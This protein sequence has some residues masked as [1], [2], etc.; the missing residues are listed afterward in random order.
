MD[1]KRIPNEV[2][3]STLRILKQANPGDLY[4][5]AYLGH[6]AKR[7]ETFFDIYH[8]AWAWAI[9]YKPKRILEIGVRTGLSICQLLSAY[10]KYDGIEKI[11]LCDVFNDG[12][13]SPELVK[14]NLQTLAIPNEVISK[15]EFLVG[16]SKIHIPT[17]LEQQFDYIL[18][19][20]SHEVSDATI[21]LENVKPLIAQ[22]G[23]IVFD[24]IDP[25]GMSLAPVWH[26]FMNK[27]QSE[28]EWHE[29][30]N[31][32]GLGWAIKL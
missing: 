17:L 29:D 26:E 7:K 11:V 20:G 4:Y 31:G 32:K 8:F 10:I 28:F 12:F 27:Y 24:D 14:A 30:Y 5:E 13:T 21:D 6:L 18:V 2:I 23:V 16:D 1:L 19:D 22:G 25:D 9:E 15:I 3:F